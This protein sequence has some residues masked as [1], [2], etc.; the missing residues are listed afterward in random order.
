M[1]EWIDEPTPLFE[2]TVEK[3]T[4]PTDWPTEDPDAKEVIR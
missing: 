3:V 1:R 4:E 2:K